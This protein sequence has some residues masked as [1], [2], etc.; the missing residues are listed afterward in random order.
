MK[1]LGDILIDSLKFAREGRHLVGEV[2]VH[3]LQRL[4]DVLADDE[5]TLAWNAA[6]K[7]DAEN[8]LF[9]V[10]EVSG[11]L[12]LKCQ[13]CLAALAFQM[14]IRSNLQLV[15]PGAAWPD[16]GLEDDR[17]DP[18]EA[19]EEQSLLSLVEDEVLLALPI[20]PRHGFCSLPGYSR[21]SAPASPFSAL[22]LLKKH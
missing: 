5:G 13:R 16:E 2:P 8:K 18:I 11:E 9:L 17:A 20:A 4:V 22:S 19:L 7:R 10:I 3:S 15:A 1:Q 14:K 21:E 12:H 6:G